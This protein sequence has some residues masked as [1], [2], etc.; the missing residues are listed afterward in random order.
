VLLG[1]VAAHSAQAGVPAASDPTPAQIYQAVRSGN[2]AAAQ[3]MVAQVVHDHPTSAKARYVA[4]EVDA[5]ARNFGLA[6]Q[7]LTTADRLEPGLPIA[8]PRS[9]AV[10]QRQ[11]G[12]TAI[13]S[14]LEEARVARA[15]EDIRAL[16]TAL[17]EFRLDNS[18][19]PTTGEGLE[20]LV[21]RPNAPSMTHWHGPYVRH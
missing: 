5:A 2:V 16:E 8:N 1:I 12:M 17:T 21:K 19:Y 4:A 7:E 13:F 11:L 18:I 20:A 3:Q 14:K 10:L 15:K 6:A 9:V